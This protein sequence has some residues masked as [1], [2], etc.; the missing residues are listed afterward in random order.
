[1]QKPTERSFFRPFRERRGAL[2]ITCRRLL[3]FL[4][5]R[6]TIDDF[7]E[8]TLTDVDV[9]EAT[10]AFYERVYFD[11]LETREKLIARMQVPLALILSIAG[12]LSYM[13]LGTSLTQMNL[14]FWVYVILIFAAFVTLIRA[15]QYFHAVLSGYKYLFIPTLWEF[16]EYRSEAIQKFSDEPEADEHLEDWVTLTLRREILKHFIACSSHNALR[17]EFRSNSSWA[18]HRLLMYSGIL[19]VMAFAI[20]RLADLRESPIHQVELVP[21]RM[22]SSHEVDRVNLIGLKDKNFLGVELN[23]L[24]GDNFHE[25]N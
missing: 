17:N 18:G 12:A 2:L 23:S 20:F 6:A 4:L 10:A 25:Q 11:S 7:P 8:P 14:I 22:E 24:N 9:D 3:D 13:A 5:C 1:M 16:E 21:Q 15:G 19:T